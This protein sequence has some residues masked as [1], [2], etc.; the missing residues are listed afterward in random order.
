MHECLRGHRFYLIVVLSVAIVL[1]V[2]LSSVV[3]QKPV[4]AD[5]GSELTPPMGLQHEVDTGRCPPVK[6]MGWISEA[7]STHW[8]IGEHVLRIDPG[9]P[10]ASNT[11]TG[12]YAIATARV[13]NDGQLHAESV[14]VQ[15]PTSPSGYTIEFSGVIQEI[16]ARYWIVGDRLVFIT[17]NTSIQGRPQIGALAEVK[18]VRLFDDMVL[19]KSVKVT[20]PGAYAEV[21]LEGMIES[22][23]ESIW[24]VSGVTVTISPVTMIRGTPALGLIAEVQGVLQPDGSVLA[25]QITV[26]GPGPASEVDIEGLVESIETTHWVVSGITVFVDAQTFIDDSRA[27]AEVGMWAQIRA[28]RRW[29]G[30]LLALRIRLSRPG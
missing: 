14:F 7:T 17:E 8:L 9:S 6:I 19:A 13:D 3:K 29:D 15:P 23:S 18:G 28:L 10:I 1:L 25:Q 27:P 24:V 21:Q 30:S 22:L 12:S 11:S 2:S 4:S 5:S 26:K 20:V 16:D